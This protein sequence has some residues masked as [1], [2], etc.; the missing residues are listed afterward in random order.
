MLVA[1]YAFKKTHRM[2]DAYIILF[3]YPLSLLVVYLLE[4]VIGLD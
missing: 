3:F 2:L 1:I 4:N